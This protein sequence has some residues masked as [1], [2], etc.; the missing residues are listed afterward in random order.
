[1]IIVLT[2]HEDSP[3]EFDIRFVQVPSALCITKDCFSQLSKLLK[4]GNKRQNANFAFLRDL[5]FLHQSYLTRLRE[6]NRAYSIHHKIHG[7]IST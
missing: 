2:I 4:P 3:D 5:H 1:M 6:E 7:S